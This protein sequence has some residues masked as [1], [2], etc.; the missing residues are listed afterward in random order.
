METASFLKEFPPIATEDWER[1][2]RETVAGEEYAAKLIWH[3]EEKLAVKPYYRA[4]DLEGLHFL[5]AG[6]GEFP[7]VRGT[8]AEGGW[9]IRERIDVGDPEEANHAA[10]QAVAAGAEEIAF[11]NSRIASASDVAFL[12]ANLDEIAIHFEGL[13]PESVR[14]VADR[15]AGRPHSAMVS[16]DIDPLADLEISEEVIRGRSEGFR[17]FAIRAVEYQESG[18][19]SFEEVGFTLSAAVDFVD[20][21]VE[22]GLSLD[23][24]TPSIGFEFA[25]GPE[26]FIQIA[27]LRAFRLL[28]AKVVE[29]FGGAGQTAKAAIHARAAQWNQ[30][31]YDPHVNMLRATTEAIS[32]V[33]GGAESISVAAFD[34][35]Y[36]VPDESSRRLARNTQ[37]ILK[38]EALLDRVADPVGGSYLI[39][40]ITHAVA[41]N[42]WRVFQELETAGGYRRAKATGVIDSV[43]GRGRVSRDKSAASR[44]LVLTGTNRF[45]NLDERALERVDPAW[46][47]PNVRVASAFEEL[48]LRTE[49]AEK[50]GRSARILLAEIGDVKMRGA[51]SQFAAE[52][53]ACAGLSART[54]R[55]ESAKRIAEEDVDVIV[56][57]SSDPEYLSIAE[58][59]LLAMDKRG[60]QARVLVAG[61][62]PAAEQMRGLGISDFIH[63]GSDAVEV[64]SRL[65]TQIGIEG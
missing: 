61:N 8:R 13:K 43:L 40:A 53:L 4:E 48:R 39:E 34:Q 14:I 41:A 3:P 58:A 17:L 31:I 55:F 9:H 60:N 59:L 42:A 50:K 6:P 7:Y 35:C 15:L 21:M 36:K 38:K 49:R 37:L 26:F 54:E 20:E 64:L 18:A 44:R 11:A 5:N 28:W 57:C 2:I 45:A 27:K 24:V 22:R 10:R 33:L 51:R 23:R 52:F 1:S 29:S 62:P 12:F 47:G 65:Q 46:L 63:L 56:L 30:T 32:A 19:G 25:M 16:A